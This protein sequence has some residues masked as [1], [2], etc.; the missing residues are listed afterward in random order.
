MSVSFEALAM[1]GVDWAEYG[2]SVEEWEREDLEMQ[3]PEHLLADEEEEEDN[4]GVDHQ[5]SIED[6]AE[7][8]ATPATKSQ[9]PSKL[10]N[11]VKLPSLEDDVMESFKAWWS[12]SKR[13]CFRAAR[14]DFNL[15]MNK[16]I[17][18]LERLL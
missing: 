7:G 10:G 17:H 13:G 9:C 1:A 5:G 8:L 14:I 18:T 15:N 6:D 2:K 11:V 3:P 4:E 16:I 12:S